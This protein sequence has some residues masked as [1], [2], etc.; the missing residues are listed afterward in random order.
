MKISEVEAASTIILAC[1][2]VAIHEGTAADMKVS[3]VRR[4]EQVILDL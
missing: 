4:T 2:A 1:K 3:E